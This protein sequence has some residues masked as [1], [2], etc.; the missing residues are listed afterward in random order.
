MS[1][2]QS[3]G[4][5]TKCLTVFCDRTEIHVKENNVYGMMHTVAKQSVSLA[6]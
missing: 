2:G 3:Y 1:S 6:F 5:S 4:S